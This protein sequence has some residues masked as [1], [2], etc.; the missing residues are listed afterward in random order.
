M[1]VVVYDKLDG[2]Q[3]VRL[4]TYIESEQNINSLYEQRPY[5]VTLV[6]IGE[7]DEQ[8]DT[9]ARYF[10]VGHIFKHVVLAF[11]NSDTVVQDIKTIRGV[12]EEKV[13]SDSSK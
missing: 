13:A 11:H 12:L 8:V 10:R 3:F 9:Q 5:N 4:M 6:R 7:I 2:K 1:G